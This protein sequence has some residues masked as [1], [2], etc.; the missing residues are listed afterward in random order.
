[1][2]GADVFSDDYKYVP[3]RRLALFIEESIDR[4]TKWAV[5]EPNDETLWEQIRRSV[6]DFMQNL[7]RQGAFQGITPDEAYFVR[8]DDSTITPEDIEQERINI[9]VGFAPLKPAEYVLIQIQQMRLQ[10]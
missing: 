8:C 6:A 7:F 1:L 9:T 5:F 3:V 2:R 10:S 4:G